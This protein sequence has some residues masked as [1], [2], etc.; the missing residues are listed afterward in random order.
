MGK[1]ESIFLQKFPPHF[2][3]SS[4]IQDS[5]TGPWGLLHHRS[6]SPSVPQVHQSFCAT[7]PLV[8][9]HSKSADPSVPNICWS[10]CFPSH[11]QLRMAV[12]LSFFRPLDRVICTSCLLALS[13]ATLKP[14]LSPSGLSFSFRISTWLAVSTILPGRG[15]CATL[16]TF[17]FH[18][19]SCWI[20]WVSSAWVL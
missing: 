7:S 17:G 13:S 16:R 12:S 20:S 11:E 5:I 3:V 4:S 10:F 8:L 9:L 1:I 15:L 19:Y 18:F 14:L 6:I 2:L